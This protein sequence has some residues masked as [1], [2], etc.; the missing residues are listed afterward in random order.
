M[1]RDGALCL[2][3]CTSHRHHVRGAELASLSR[4]GARNLAWAPGPEGP[5]PGPARGFRS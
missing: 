3:H 2:Q 5:H 1:V 4:A